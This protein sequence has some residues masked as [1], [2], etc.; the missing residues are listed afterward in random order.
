MKFT[1]NQV[2]LLAGLSIVKNS[3]STNQAN[4]LLQ[5][6]LLETKND[7]LK[8][9]T[10][11]LHLFT[12]TEVKIEGEEDGKALLPLQKLLA[13]AQV[14]PEKSDVKCVLKKNSMTLSSGKVKFK[15]TGADIENVPVTPKILNSIN[16]KLEQKDL[17]Q[18]IA[19]TD[20]AVHKDFTRPALAG[21]LFEIKD[22]KL[23]IVAT[24]GK[25]LAMSSQKVSGDLETRVIM[26]PKLT[27]ELKRLLT[28]GELAIDV[29][30]DKI[31]FTFGKTKIV[32]TLIEGMYPAYQKIIPEKTAPIVLD[33]DEFLLAI[34]RASV[35]VDSNSLDI[36]L[37]IEKGKLS[38]FKNVAEE[39]AVET[40]DIENKDLDFEVGFDAEF[41]ADGIKNCSKKV[42]DLEVIDNTRP[43]MIREDNFS[44]ILL[45]ILIEE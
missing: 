20:F 25:R 1:I 10:T 17:Q 33:K 38:I 41:L 24:D 11:D 32:S 21:T 15:I 44:Y 39:Q 14:M 43:G 22:N 7:S 36:K 27:S 12:S 9:A 18:L 42:I 5:N 37:K 19:H 40:L 35:L 8:L 31:A 34:K 6:V 30:D 45:P 3:I 23:N 13:I 29:S 16:I 28:S 4:F 2:E 26:P